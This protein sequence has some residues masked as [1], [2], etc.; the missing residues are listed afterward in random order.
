MTAAQYE[1]KRGAIAGKN[2][3]FRLLAQNVSRSDSLAA[4]DVM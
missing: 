1:Q 4:T 3:L 2:D